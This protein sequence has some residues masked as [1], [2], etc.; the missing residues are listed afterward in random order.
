MVTTHIPYRDM[1]MQGDGTVLFGPPRRAWT[2]YR[3]L[4]VP[5]IKWNRAQGLAAVVSTRSEHGVHVIEMR[6]LPNLVPCSEVRGGLCFL[7]F[8]GAD[9]ELLKRMTCAWVDFLIEGE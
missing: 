7:D 3:V 5:P 1:E 8:S 9:P 2:G 4:A 6:R